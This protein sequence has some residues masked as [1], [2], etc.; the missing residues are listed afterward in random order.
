MLSS[1]QQRTACLLF[2]LRIIDD[3]VHNIL[4]CSDHHLDIPV[5]YCYDD[6]G[7]SYDVDV[8]CHD[9]GGDNP[10]G[11]KNASAFTTDVNAAPDTVSTIDK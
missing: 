7:Y 10:I 4:E 3:I 5:Y 8:L 6:D 2:I 11:I 1:P 9:Y